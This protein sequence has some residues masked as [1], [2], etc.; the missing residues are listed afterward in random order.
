M[1]VDW[2]GVFVFV[3]VFVYWYSSHKNIWTASLSSVHTFIHIS[4]KFLLFC[5]VTINIVF[6]IVLVQFSSVIQWCPSLCIPMNCSTA[7]LSCPSPTPKFTQIY[8]HQIGDAIQP[9]HPMSSPSPPAYNLS[10]H[11]SL[12]QSVS[13]SNQVTKLL[14]LLLQHQSFQWIFRTDFL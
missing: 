13:S 8:V 9:S 10:Q 1:P 12:F 4:K 7:S 14:E 6:M 2:W 3:F 11:Q 5:I